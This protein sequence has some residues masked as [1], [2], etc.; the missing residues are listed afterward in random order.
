[1]RARWAESCVRNIA[2]QHHVNGIC[3]RTS[4][5]R[6]FQKAG[7]WC[8]PGNCPE[9]E[10]RAKAIDALH[11]ILQLEPW[12]ETVSG[13][14]SSEA[15]TNRPCLHLALA[16]PGALFRAWVDSK[17]L[18]VQGAVWSLGS[19]PISCFDFSRA[20]NGT[21]RMLGQYGGCLSGACGSDCIRWYTFRPLLADKRSGTSHRVMRTQVPQTLNPKP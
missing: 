21:L 7:R 13:I 5:P 10:K 11:V 17:D 19:G 14:S 6:P 4:I 9:S 12:Q 8:E 2:A 18:C 16:T 20:C 1:M 3:D 15:V